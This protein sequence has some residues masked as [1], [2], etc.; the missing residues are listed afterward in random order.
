MTL[1]V[2]CGT[3]HFHSYYL[4]DCSEIISDIDEAHLFDD[5]IE[6]CDQ[7]ATAGT[8][9]VVVALIGNQRRKCFKKILKLLPK[10]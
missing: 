2:S 10:V 9:F 8:S 1:Y 6:M 3:L 7:L 4:N 5:I